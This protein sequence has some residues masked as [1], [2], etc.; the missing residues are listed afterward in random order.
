MCESFARTAPLPFRGG[1]NGHT[2]VNLY[3]YFIMPN[4]SNTS[5]RS[6][7][8]E[9]A[10][11]PAPVA[12][13][14]RGRG[15]AR[16]TTPDP[17]EQAASA[18]AANPPEAGGASTGA[19]QPPTGGHHSD[20]ESES[21]LSS[22]SYESDNG[23]D[24]AAAA[25]AAASLARTDERLA[26][27]G[28]SEQAPSDRHAASQFAARGIQMLDPNQGT[29]AS[30]PASG[31]GQAASSQRQVRG[32]PLS[33]TRPQPGLAARMPRPVEPGLWSAANGYGRR[34]YPATAHNLAPHGLASSTAAPGVQAPPAPAMPATV[35]MGPTRESARD[36][37][38]RML[39]A[40]HSGAGPLSLGGYA[41][42]PPGP[43]RESPRESV[44]RALHD[45]HPV[46][47]LLST[48]QG[49]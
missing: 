13:R 29:P 26:D 17:R 15:S 42:A 7:A 47:G 2:Q 21:S 3:V 25:D 38:G 40:E 45:V 6:A 33:R 18:A 34:P 16:A 39:R 12:T 1:F 27:F 28:S 19:D 9:A 35:P 31:S 46:P 4:R 30:D 8:A 36:S 11:A 43:P 23:F 20:S 32:E 41:S 49:R 14:T 24:H 22:V 5:R 44:R 10:P 37:M 48:R